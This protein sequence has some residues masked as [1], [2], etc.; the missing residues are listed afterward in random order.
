[1]GKGGSENGSRVEYIQPRLGAGESPILGRLPGLQ[2][3]RSLG[4][5]YPCHVRT[6]LRQE[7]DSPAPS[8]LFSHLCR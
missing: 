2:G 7:G 6:F 5:L 1:M 8:A 4:V 3:S